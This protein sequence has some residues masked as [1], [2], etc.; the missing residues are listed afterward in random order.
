MVNNSPVKG[1]MS[2][3]PRRNFAMVDG[4]M[5][6]FGENVKSQHTDKPIVDFRREI[7]PKSVQKVIEEGEM[8]RCAC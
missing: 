2:D 7:R 8:E 1:L 3:V 6:L 4:N 5:A